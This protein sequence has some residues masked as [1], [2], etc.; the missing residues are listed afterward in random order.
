MWI[1][2]AFCWISV[3]PDLH[4]AY[5]GFDWIPTWNGVQRF[6]FTEWIVFG[7]NFKICMSWVKTKPA[8]NCESAINYFSNFKWFVPMCHW[9]G[10]IIQHEIYYQKWNGDRWKNVTITAQRMRPTTA[11]QWGVWNECSTMFIY[12]MCPKKPIEF[13]QP[14]KRIQSVR[15]FIESRTLAIWSDSSF[16][17][18][19]ETKSNVQRDAHIKRKTRS[20]ASFL[21]QLNDGDDDDSKIHQSSKNDSIQRASKFSFTFFFSSANSCLPNITMSIANSMSC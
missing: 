18:P 20:K 14:L 15:A 12:Q 1:E 5:K 3:W 2:F 9:W 7:F 4:S 13:V 11:N 16:D 17:F 10:Y 6:T 19:F 8:I 21:N